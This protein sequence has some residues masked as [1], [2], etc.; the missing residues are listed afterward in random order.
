IDR[1]GDQDF[2]RIEGRA[3]EDVVAEVY[4][5]RLDSP[6]DSVLRLTDAAGKE[7]AVNDDWEDKG[8]GLGTHHADSYLRATLPADGVYY[9]RLSDTQ[10]KGGADYGYRLRISAPRPD[11]ELRVTPSSL[12]ARAGLS[13]PFT[14]FALR[15]DGFSNEIS[16]T[17]KEAP[18]GFRLSGGRIAA[19]QDQARMTL[20]AGATEAGE[21]VGIELEGRAKVCGR[22]IVHRAVPAED[23]MQAFAYRH[24]VPVKQLAVAVTGRGGFR[25]PK[26]MG[27]SPVKIVPGG[28]ALVRI[29]GPGYLDRFR[30]ELIDAPQGITIREVKSIGSGAEILLG[31]DA[32]KAKP[33]LQ[34]NL[35]VNLV[36][37][38]G[39]GGAGKSPPVQRRVAAGT[40]PAIAFEIVAPRTEP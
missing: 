15:R 9:F 40:L 38:P 32:G 21:P 10:N 20:T 25:A 28:T 29:E 36:P 33:G 8:Y 6:L 18:P 26:V 12:N 5:R 14:V 31:S 4:A 11:F 39:R 16:V 22:E 3:G 35:I 7:L 13:V 1:P 23:M 19:G 2:F 24:L 30:F 17:L 27:E 37:I 34:G